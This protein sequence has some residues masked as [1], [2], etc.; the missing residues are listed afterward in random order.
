MACCQGVALGRRG[1]EGRRPWPHLSPSVSPSSSDPSGI[2]PQG[3]CGSVQLYLGGCDSMT[4]L[5]QGTPCPLRGRPGS[6]RS[7]GA[8]WAPGWP[9]GLAASARGPVSRE[10][11]WHSCRGPEACSGAG[12]ATARC[13]EAAWHHTAPIRL[14]TLAQIQ[15][16]GPPG[17]LSEEDVP[18]RA[19]KGRE[20]GRA[21]DLK[22]QLCPSRR[23]RPGLS[24]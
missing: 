24:L 16:E 7:L 20:T 2:C 12:L 5:S 4:P 11:E 1:A 14:G 3:P 19:W 22:S 21:L 9:S 8:P 18:L 10:D 6:P 23:P 15:G 13:P 17:G